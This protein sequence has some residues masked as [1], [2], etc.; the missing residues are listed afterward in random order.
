MQVLLLSQPLPLW[1]RVARLGPL[2]YS[3][4]N[5]QGRAAVALSVDSKSQDAA[6]PCGEVIFRACCAAYRLQQTAHGAM[7]EL[8]LHIPASNAGRTHAQ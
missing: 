7:D 5:L 1:C 3:P 6:Q 2:K 4:F 8:A